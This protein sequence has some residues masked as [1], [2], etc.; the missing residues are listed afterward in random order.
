MTSFWSMNRDAMLETNAGV[1]SQYEFTEVFKK[2]EE[3]GDGGITPPINTAPILKGIENKKVFIGETFDAMEGVTAIDKE[4]GNLTDKI[5]V[6]GNVDTNIAGA[7]TLIYT[8]EDSEGL[9]TT[10]ERI[11][12][13]KEK[14]DITDDNFDPNKIYLEGDTVIYKGEKYTAKWWT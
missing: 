13:V 3:D 14:P 10:K 1:S 7:Y 8:V 12:T 5:I 2:F 4:D 11:I 6:T 9:I